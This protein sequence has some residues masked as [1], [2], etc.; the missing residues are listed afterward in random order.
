MGINVRLLFV[1]GAVAAIATVAAA[2]AWAA[3]PRSEGGSSPAG[4]ITQIETAHIETSHVETSRVAAGDPADPTQSVIAPF[5]D[6]LT[7]VSGASRIETAIAASERYSP[8]VPAV[9]VATAT[10]FPDALSAAS[11]SAFVGGP[12]LLTAR[13]TLPASVLAEVQ[14]LTPEHIYVVGGTGAVSDDVLEGLATVAPTT[15]FAGSDRYSTG[16][17]IVQGTFT[18]STT[19]FIATGASFPDALAATGAAGASRSPVILVDGQR[20]SLSGDTVSLLDELGVTDVAIAGGTSVVSSSIEQ[21]LSLSGRNVIRY[22]G[23]DRYSTAAIIN[24]AFFAPGTD[25]AFLAT[26]TAFPDALA[27]AALAGRLGAPLYV[28]Q[29]ACMPDVTRAALAVLGNVKTVVMGGTAAVSAASAEGLGCLSGPAPTITGTVRVGSTLTAHA[30]TWTDGTSLA[31]QWYANGVPLSGA[32]ASTLGLSS[33]VQ[34]KRISVRVTGAQTGYVSLTRSSSATAPV[35]AKSTPPPP[36]PGPPANPGDSKNC[37]DFSTWRQ[38][39]SWFLTYY[40]YYGD[41][42][43]LDADHDGIACESLPGAP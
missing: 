18:Q 17:A 15:R 38:A 42:A 22:G 27:G 9:F 25:T 6:G 34:G 11:A 36:P 5:P 4:R 40:P 39:Q 24:A 43:R 32:T 7:R 19:A 30:G 29:P 1:A 14:R 33:A 8:G 35:A 41:V 20:S 13:D 31:Y 23:G 37:S 3:P 21:Q 26:G 16:T 12:L 2:P 10:N 28:T